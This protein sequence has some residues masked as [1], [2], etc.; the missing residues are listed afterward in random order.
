[1]L[2]RAANYAKAVTR[3]AA[4]GKPERTDAEVDYLFREF[5]QPCEMLVNGKCTGCGCPVKPTSEESK[6]GVISKSLLNKLRMGTERCPIGKWPQPDEPIPTADEIAA[7]RGIIQR[8]EIG[9]QLE[10][11]EWTPAAREAMRQEIADKPWQPTTTQGHGRGIVILGG[12]EKYFGGAFVLIRMLRELGCRLPIELWIRNWTEIDEP[13]AALIEHFPDVTIRNA[14][15]NAG[16]WQTKIVA[17]QESAF[18]EVLYL[19][20]D[21]VPVCDPTDL[22]DGDG[23]RLHGAMLWPDLPTDYGFDIERPAWSICGLPT[24]GG[25]SLPDGKQHTRPTGYT[26]IESGQLLIDKRRCGESLDVVRWLNEHSEFFYREPKKKPYL[27]GDK[28]TFLLGFQMAKKE[29]ATAP[30]GQMW[31]QRQCGGI[32]HHDESGKVVWQH[33]THPGSKVRP[34]DR[35]AADGL[36]AAEA[37]RESIAV[38]EMNWHGKVWERP[39]AW[40]SYP[41][42]QTDLPTWDLWGEIRDNHLKLPARMDGQT[43]VDIGGHVGL[44]AFACWVRG[45]SRVVSVEPDDV[46]YRALA[47]NA[48]HMGTETIHGAAWHRTGILHLSRGN[49]SGAHRICETGQPV[50]A[51]ELDGLLRSLGR[52]DLLKLDCEGSEWGLVATSNELHRVGRIVGEYHCFRDGETVDSWLSLL[53]SRGFAATAERGGKWGLFW[54][55]R[56]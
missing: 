3:W 6:N 42:R 14:R 12:G 32:T 34:R 26:P 54:A 10:R 7:A 29:Y 28:S 33:R 24:P 23:Y 22:F 5:C 56:Q 43:I 53:R 36:I 4:A 52:I 15:T 27:Y 38:L 41:Q 39:P 21:I 55:D 48:A 19:D 31:M 17:I 40:L 11:W 49:H 46:S 50:N 37:F 44:F 47:A 30:D 8:H 20:S 9:Q 18:A 35:N 51:V 25:I 45:A 16:G 1:M 2:T 13:M